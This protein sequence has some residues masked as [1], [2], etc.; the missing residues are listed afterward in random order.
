MKTRAMPLRKINALVPFQESHVKDIEKI[1][2]LFWEIY[3]S[4][5]AYKLSPT[6]ITKQGVEKKFDKM[7]FAK[8]SCTLLNKVL[9][10]IYNNREELLLVLK[11]PGLALHNNLS[12]RDI[13]E[14]VKN[15]KLAEVRAAMRDVEVVIR[16]R[17]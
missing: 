15:E 9:E 12:V 6:D 14:Y 17:L 4:L 8:T 10:R 11:Y 1:L 5:K 2:G 13:R 16:L 3:A 7:C